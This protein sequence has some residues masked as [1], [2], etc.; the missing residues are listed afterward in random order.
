MVYS[1]SSKRG[2]IK[3][4]AAGEPQMKSFQRKSKN[5]EKARFRPSGIAGICMFISSVLLFCSGIAQGEDYI[6]GPWDIY[7]LHYSGEKTKCTPP[8]EFF[9]KRKGRLNPPYLYAYDEQ[10]ETRESY[11]Y[12]CRKHIDKKLYLSFIY[13][14][15]PNDYGDSF[16]MIKNK[17]IPKT[18]KS[19]CPHQ[20]E[21]PEP[22]LG[23]SLY[24]PEGS[25]FLP[26]S[27]LK[28]NQFGY[29][30]DRKKKGPDR[31]LAHSGILSEYN[32]S[33]TV[34]Y[35]HEGNWLIHKFSP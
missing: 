13:R 29:L 19:Q 32:G 27:P 25:P 8:A 6:V 33:G 17:D 22:P 26:G 21:W 30:D 3:T 5:Q 1:F 10:L 28:L 12:W 20:I 24:K 11:V 18:E 7:N 23:L 34:F 15:L 31:P 16:A 35:C 4:I 9:M 14:S 2:L